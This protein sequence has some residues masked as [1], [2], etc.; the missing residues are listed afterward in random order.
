M[1]ADIQLYCRRCLVCASRNDPGR[2]K[3]PPLQPIP[4][5]GPFHRV[6]VD[7]LQL[8]MSMDG[9]KYAVVFMEYFTK[10]PEVFAVPHQMAET[11]TRLLVEQ[12][13]HRH[14]VTEQLLSDQ[15]GKSF[16][17]SLVQEACKLISTKKINTSG[18]HP[19]C[20]GL[21]E[22]FNSTLIN[23]L[24]KSVGKYGRDWDKHL[25]YL[26]FA[27]RV[28]MQEST[29]TSPFYLLYGREPQV[30]ISDAL[31]QPRTIYQ[32]DFPDYL[33]GMV[34][35]LSDA[36][37]LAHHNI[38]KAQWKQKEKYDKKSSA[39]TLKV[40]ETFFPESGE[41]QGMEIS[42]ALLWFI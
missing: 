1:Q 3:C 23:M 34:A 40:G 24:S 7:V 17:S 21:V 22:K 41:G 26:L 14:G 19:Q 4:V 38:E 9:K 35:I 28:T 8:S 15:R 18:Y 2:V 20:D 39:S 16:L 36:W 10:W 6:E 37:G 42:L 11:I 29:K 27:Y 30:P 31:A 5:E 25:P 32:V 13:I 33:T 12:V